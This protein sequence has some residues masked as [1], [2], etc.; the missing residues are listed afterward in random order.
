MTEKRFIESTL[1]VGRQDVA[2]SRDSRVEGSVGFDRGGSSPSIESLERGEKGKFDTLLDSVVEGDAGISALIQT[3][4]FGNVDAGLQTVVEVLNS[5]AVPAEKLEELNRKLT[6]FVDDYKKSHVANR[7]LAK[8][9][10]QTISDLVED[11]L[12]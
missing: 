9:V 2:T 11:Y 8:D 5:E 1:S 7:Q 12:Q 4:V 6:A 10:S 3:H